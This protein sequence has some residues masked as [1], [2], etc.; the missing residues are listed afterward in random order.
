MW[1]RP[2]SSEASSGAGPAAFETVQE[3]IDSEDVG[4][5]PVERQCGDVHCHRPSS[6]ASTGADQAAFETLERR[7]WSLA[8][9]YTRSL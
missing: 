1:R 3:N 4:T 2:P 5:A 6:E 8:V 7:K 9:F